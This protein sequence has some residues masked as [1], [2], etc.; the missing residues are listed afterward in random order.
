[1]HRRN[2]IYKR[3][4]QTLKNSQNKLKLKMKI[5]LNIKWLVLNMFYDA[6]TISLVAVAVNYFQ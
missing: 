2:P 3:S 4:E 6:R 1:M 5:F